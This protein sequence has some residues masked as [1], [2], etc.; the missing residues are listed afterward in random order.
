VIGAGSATLVLACG[1]AV[2]STEVLPLSIALFV[3]GVGW[4]FCYVGGSALLSDLLSPEE[5]AKSQGANDFLIGLATAG[6]SAG[7]GLL[8]AS[9]SYTVLGISGA[10]VS[11]VPLGLATWWMA[12][13]R[14]PAVACC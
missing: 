2:L 5:R 8:F 7:S 1:L 3:L 13:Q 12:R 9:T 6:A 10:M 4:S 14:R 11:L